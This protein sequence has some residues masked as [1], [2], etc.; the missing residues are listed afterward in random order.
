MEKDLSAKIPKN[1]GGYPKNPL[2]FSFSLFF[3]LP[4]VGRRART[5][6][7]RHVLPASGQDKAA[8]ET[9][10]SSSPSLTPRSFPLFLRTPEKPKPHRRRDLSPPAI[11]ASPRHSE[12]TTGTAVLR[13]TPTP[14]TASWDGLNRV[15]FAVSFLSDRRTPPPIPPPPSLLRPRRPLHRA[16]RITVSLPVPS[17]RSLPLGL[18]SPPFTRGR[19]RSGSPWSLLQIGRASC[20]ERVCLY[21]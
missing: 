12:T 21:V 7:P 15:D 11:D 2:F 16:P 18:A 19:R 8:A 1:S 6:L 14:S 20:R 13:S 5:A 4:P 9:S 17:F 10:S 3:F